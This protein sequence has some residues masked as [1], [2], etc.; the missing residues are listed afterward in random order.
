M[1]GLTGILIM[2]NEL[3]AMDVLVAR[4]TTI[5]FPGKSCGGH[6][7]LW[8]KR[9]M[10]LNTRDRQVSAIQHKSRLLVL[11]NGKGSGFKALNRMTDPTI[12]SILSLGKLTIVPV[13]VTGSAGQVTRQLL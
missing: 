10:A 7:R 8:L 3:I 4:F 5:L 13:F 9:F 12:A 6:A 2:R 11:G 1:T